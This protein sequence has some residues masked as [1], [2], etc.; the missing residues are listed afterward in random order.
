MGDHCLELVVSVV[1]IRLNRLRVTD[2]LMAGSR[3]PRKDAFGTART[4]DKGGSMTSPNAVGSSFCK[5]G[6]KISASSG[7]RLTAV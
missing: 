4:A 2:A 6:V 1:W 5:R 7:H 3:D